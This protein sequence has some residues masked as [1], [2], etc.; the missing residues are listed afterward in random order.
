MKNENRILLIATIAGIAFCLWKITRNPTPNEALLLSLFMTLLSIFASWI[1]SKHY[2]KASYEDSLKVF[3]LKAAEKVTNLSNE[4]DR[5]A[6]FLQK[7]LDDDDFASPVEELLAKTIRFEDAIHLITALRSVNDTSLSDWRGVIGSELS[8]Q[9]EAQIEEQEEREDNLRD[10]MARLEDIQ[11][12]ALET[13]GLKES[14][15][16]EKVRI[17]L[18]AIRNDMRSLASQ[19]GGVR[20]APTK[21]RTFQ[22]PCPRCQEPIEYHYNTKSQATKKV[23]C[24]SCHAKLYASS[25]GAESMLRE[26]QPLPETLACPICATVTTRDLDPLFGT[27]QEY[28]CPTCYSHL[29]AI[30]SRGG[31]TIRVVNPISIETTTAPDNS[32]SLPVSDDLL[33]KVEIAMGFQPWPKGRSQEVR[34]QLK[35]SLATINA[36]LEELISRGIFKHQIGGVLYEPIEGQP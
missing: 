33:Q 28:G 13:A 31:I 18:G 27:M 29:R 22:N 35:L 15:E 1:V 10:I 23:D 11:R 4:L 7:S 34:S 32:T 14:L 20:L 25:N 8:K 36:A 21:R 24:P 3:A 30:R 17:E 5:L 9:R 26:R 12:E 16:R 6:T 2:A 19:V